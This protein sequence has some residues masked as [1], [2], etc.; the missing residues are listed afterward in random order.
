MI[1]NNNKFSSKPRCYNRKY[2]LI[3]LNMKLASLSA[4]GCERSVIVQIEFEKPEV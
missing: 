4:K 1:A 3:S 2:K